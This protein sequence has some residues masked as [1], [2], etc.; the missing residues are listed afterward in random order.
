MILLILIFGL[1]CLEF[2]NLGKMEME[3]EW[4]G[5]CQI[6]DLRNLWPC[7]ECW[8]AVGERC[9]DFKFRIFL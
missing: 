1:E 4:G 3:M 2:W 5:A 8:C 9:V 7:F 6:F